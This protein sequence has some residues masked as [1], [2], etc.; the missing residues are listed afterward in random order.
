[1]SVAAHARLFM[2]F[3]MFS[4]EFTNASHFELAASQRQWDRFPLPQWDFFVVP[5]R[6]ELS[7]F[8]LEN[9]YSIH[10]SYGT[11]FCTPCEDRTRIFRSKAECT[12]HYANGAIFCMGS[13]VVHVIVSC[14]QRNSRMLRIS[15]LRPP[16]S[17][18]GKQPPLSSHIWFGFFSFSRDSRSR[19]S[20]EP[21]F[22][23]L[24]F[25][26]WFRKGSNFQLPA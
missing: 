17:K 15:N 3:F 2:L 20:T 5:E 25:W 12:H 9:R 18:A 24:C 8:G 11:V 26:W 21:F 16:A 4:M 22:H 23:L 14:F 19:K 7:T 6:I 13:R 1:M 10:L